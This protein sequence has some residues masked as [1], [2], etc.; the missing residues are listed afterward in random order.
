ME[1]LSLCWT[2]SGIKVG[3]KIVVYDIWIAENDNAGFL[4]VGLDNINKLYLKEQPISLPMVPMS[5]I[6]TKY[7][8]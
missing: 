7:D 3:V 2:W 1:V 6:D 4:S 5:T 8:K